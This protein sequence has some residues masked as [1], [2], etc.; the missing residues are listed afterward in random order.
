MSKDVLF[1]STNLFD[2]YLPLS[3]F[4]LSKSMSE[5]G[6]RVVY[7]EFPHTYLSYLKKDFKYES[8]TRLNKISNNYFVLRSFPILP[9]FKKSRFFNRVD[10]RI[11]YTY[12]RE[13]LKEIDFKPNLVWS[14]VPFFPDALQA[15]S[16]KRVYD[17]VDDY[18]SLPGLI[19]PYYVLELERKTVS[20][21]DKV[22][23]TESVY[24]EERMRNFGKEPVV[25][26]NGVN[27][28]VFSKWLETAD[29][30]QIKK[31]IIYVGNVSHWFDFELFDDIADSFRDFEIMIVGFASVDVSLFKKHPNINF[32][33]RLMQQ[34]FA[35]LLAESSVA[36]I[37]FK[38][39][40]I[41]KATDPLK[42][43]EYLAAGVPVVST[44]VGNVSRLPVYVATKEDFVEKI[45]EAI[46]EDSIEKRKSQTLFAKQFSWETKYAIVDKIIESL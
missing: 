40:E 35:Q 13:S 8:G 17:C 19:D 16:S 30:L 33:G 34:E 12:I 15:F 14:Y 23:V 36:I 2:P 18:S 3:K 10:N 37:P 26:S 46:K 29:T 9:F 22:I 20:L 24:L 1:L 27:Y 4:W 7:S 25:L 31:R 45:R 5:N 39:N 42:V 43:Y 28:E 32:V 21:V 44:H 11:F 38:E 41:T 6:F